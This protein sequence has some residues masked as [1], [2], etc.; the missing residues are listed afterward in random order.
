[1]YCR[2]SFRYER[3]IHWRKCFR[4]GAYPD[5]VPYACMQ[6]PI[7]TIENIPFKTQEYPVGYRY[8]LRL[9]QL[10]KCYL[11]VNFGNHGNTQN[12]P[13]ADACFIRPE[14]NLGSFFLND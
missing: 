10:V 6:K 5:S 1:M 13:I 3:I 4:L 11:S 14:E 2:Q 9:E 12:I 8:S 7:K